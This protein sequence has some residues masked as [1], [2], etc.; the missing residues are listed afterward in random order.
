MKHSTLRWN[1]LNP[2]ELKESRRLCLPHSTSSG[3]AER[4]KDKWWSTTLSPERFAFCWDERNWKA[5]LLQPAL[6]CERRKQLER[7]ANGCL[8]GKLV[9]NYGWQSDL[10]LG[11]GSRK[12]EKAFV[13]AR[14][15]PTN[16]PEHFD[17]TKSLQLKAG[18]RRK[19]LLC[20]FVRLSSKW[21]TSVCI[22]DPKFPPIY[23]PE[24]NP[25]ESKAVES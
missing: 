16:C 7:K 14:V 6:D 18:C 15:V 5:L 20:V 12:T 22:N 24:F 17:S 13:G 3:I 4:S 23:D 9:E 8:V 21:T 2:V 11:E 10:A 19:C 25:F 1:H